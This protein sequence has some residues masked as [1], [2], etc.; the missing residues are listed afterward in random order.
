V[1]LTPPPPDQ[2]QPKLVVRNTKVRGADVWAGKPAVFRFDLA[3]EGQAPL[4]IRLTG[5]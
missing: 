1:D 3:N 4:A 5:G 2:P